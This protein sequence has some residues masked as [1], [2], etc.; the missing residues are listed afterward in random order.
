VIVGDHLY[1]LNEPGI[2]WCMEV[3]TGKR[4]WQQRLGTA[5]CWSS[6]CYVDGRLYVVNMDGTT[7]VLKP[8]PTACQVIAE[9]KLEELTRGSLAFSQG[10][11]VVRSYNHL[12]CIGK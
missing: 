5:K 3:A 11:I 9:N 6:M 12:Y 4:L 10:K 1:I 2:A 8:D 7:F